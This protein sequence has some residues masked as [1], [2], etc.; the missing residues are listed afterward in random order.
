MQSRSR[1]QIGLLVALVFASCALRLLLL[2]E[3]P[4]WFDE[5][6][7][8]W[9]SR[10]RLTDLVAALRLDSGPPNFYVIAKPFA[11][12]A[13]RV[14]DGDRLVRVPSFVAA[15]LLF[16]AARTVPKGS[17]RSCFVLLLSCSLL[18]NL[19]SGE[20]RPYAL[21]ALLCLTLFLLAL[22]GEETSGRLCALAGA[23][24][25]ALYT[26]YLAVFAVAAL[27]L[28]TASARRRRSCLAL[29]AGAALFAP[30]APVLLAQPAAAVAWMRET[31]VG[32]IV[33]FLSALGGVGR[34]PAQFGPP[35]PPALFFA[36]AA[37]GV[38][39]LSLLL[40][41]ARTDRAARE[42]AAFILL[43]LTGALAAS[44][45]KPVAFAGRTELAVLPVWIWGLAR[46]IAAKRSLRQISAVSAVL[47][48]S[49]TLAVVLAEH[50]PSPPVAVAETITRVAGKGDIV[51][52][53][54]AFYLPAR[55]ASE[56]GRLAAAVK[57]LTA[58]L[59][60]HPG[61]FVPSLP[62][63]EE[64]RLLASAT[65]ELAPGRR[66]FLVIPP[67]YAT[68]GLERVLA[69]GGGHARALMHSQDALVVL[70]TKAP[71]TPSFR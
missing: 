2:F 20:G 57:P 8:I 68:P 48:L 42:S 69:R 35:A 6:F 7:T 56:Q 25:L 34:V 47:G 24:A 66:L 50:S 61:W 53:A 41:Y 44:I 63:S 39:S 70:W 30:W 16:A 14:A 65:A 31:P 1:A 11:V 60:R 40:A 67:V 17:A 22:D 9:A 45:W 12:I 64:E 19:Y 52:A 36:G 37:A 28:L 21:L 13:D 59:G 32:S 27:L 43:V 18:V 62:G 23:G 5:L 58:E 3:R 26:H 38:L 49:G 29:A 46:A 55:L 33:G 54:A 71:E 51:V 10:L 15:L 4:L